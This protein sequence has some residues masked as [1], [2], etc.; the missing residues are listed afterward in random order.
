MSAD[1]PIRIAELL[2]QAVHDLVEAQLM[3]DQ[4]QLGLQPGSLLWRQARTVG[5]RIHN[6]LSKLGD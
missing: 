1:A 2:D 4:L 5:D 6:A 3:V